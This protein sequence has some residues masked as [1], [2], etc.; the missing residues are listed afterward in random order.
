[1]LP[2]GELR[3]WLLAQPAAERQRALATLSQ[4]E[5]ACLRAHWEIWARP[6]QLPPP[7]DWPVW[8]ICAGRGFGKTRAGAEWVCRQARD[9]HGARI[10]LVGASIHEARAVMVEGESGVLAVMRHAAAGHSVRF[11]PSLRRLV[12]RNGAQ[13]TLYSAA[14]PESL[15]GAQHS[16][17]W[18]DEIG[19]WE[20]S[21]DRSTAATPW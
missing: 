13:A 1:M 18:C 7:G 10:A 9:H 11:E 5:R 4:A 17:A 12:W 2:P 21:G 6:E 20:A 16:H 15:R 3:E 14:E 19:K 8:L